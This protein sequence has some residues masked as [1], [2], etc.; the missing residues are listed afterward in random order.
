MD[1]TTALEVLS[2]LNTS[3]QTGVLKRGKILLMHIEVDGRL[4]RPEPEEMR[5]MI[6]VQETKEKLADYVGEGTRYCG[7]M[8]L[9]KFWKSLSPAESEYY[10]AEFS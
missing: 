8:E 6:A 4:V 2:G 10:L 5:R 3:Y 7:S 9:T 1:E